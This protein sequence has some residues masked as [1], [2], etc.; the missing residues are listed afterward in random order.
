MNI[1]SYFRNFALNLNR[2]TVINKKV[3]KCY[4]PLLDNT[5]VGNIKGITSI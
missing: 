5:N 3:L 4:L 1:K 2:K